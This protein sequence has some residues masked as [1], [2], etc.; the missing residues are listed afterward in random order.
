MFEVVWK[1]SRKSPKQTKPKENSLEPLLGGN[2]LRQIHSKK[3][4]GLHNL[5][6]LLVEIWPPQEKHKKRLRMVFLP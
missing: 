2:S 5:Q 1:G 3:R 4:Q 6:K